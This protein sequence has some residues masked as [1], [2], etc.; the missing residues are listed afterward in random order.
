M[1]A[2]RASSALPL[3]YG[4]AG[5]AGCAIGLFGTLTS[6]LLADAGWSEVEVGQN[7]SVFFL[8]MMAAAPPAA[9]ALRRWGLRET[10]AAGLLLAA[11]SALCFPLAHGPQ[12]WTA[13]RALLGLGVGGYMIAGQT[14]LATLAG[15]G[16][17][18][19][20]S[21]LQA[22]AFGLGVGLGPLLG[23]A[24]YPHS[25]VAA[26]GAG[27]AAMLLGQGLVWRLPARPPAPSAPADFGLWRRVSLPLHAVFA[28]GAAEATLV[29]LFPVFMRSRGYEI[30][31]MGVAF[32]AFVAGSLVS[33][34]PVTRA[35]GRWG[36]RRAMGG[37]AAGGVAACVAL[38]LLPAAAPGWLVGSVSAAAG[39]A[40]GPLFALALA[41]IG[42]AL[43]AE[44]L[45]GGTALFT[46]AFG[47]GSL[48]APWL[49]GLAMQAW[50]DAHLFTLTAALLAVLLL[51]LA[52][53]LQRAPQPGAHIARAQE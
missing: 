18:A 28:Y 27:A 26:F 35:A 2:D 46:V 47:L 19:A 40:V 16:R 38:G 29:S 30:G 15:A 32:G 13:L 53:D 6:T 9:A 48:G 21:G 39:A 33:V 41:A 50:G 25:P 23:A 22:L 36:M 8:C 20:A 5:L 7:G 52:L 3:L 1:S 17:R 24:L 42:D 14:A 10:L 31:E 51:R 49:S 44:R 12:A 34:V 45:P 37:C 4:V 43:P 11:A